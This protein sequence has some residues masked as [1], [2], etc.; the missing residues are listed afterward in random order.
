MSPRNRSRCTDPHWV[1]RSDC[2]AC[3]VRASMLF[4][5]MDETELDHVLQPIDHFLAPPG[6]E[7][8]QAGQPA[9]EVVSLRR[10]VLKVQHLSPEG[11]HR[12]VALLRPGDIGGLEA[13][14][15]GRYRHSVI[16]VTEVDFCRIPVGA[17]CALDASHPGVHAALRRLW[18]ER[19]QQA[20]RFMLELLSGEAATRIARL[21]CFLD[22]FRTDGQPLRLSRQDMA[23]M[24]DISYETASRVCSQFQQRGWLDESGARIAIDRPRLEAL[25]AA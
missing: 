15:A 24:V 19:L 8:L 20:E 9:R 2:H 18:D 13:L 6:A 10:G 1:G 4:S 14:Q 16:A 17:I 25:V 21:L 12:I 22:A 11:R 23:A 7:L 5:A 3:A